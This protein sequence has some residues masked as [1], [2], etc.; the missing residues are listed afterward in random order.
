MRISITFLLVIVAVIAAVNGRKPKAFSCYRS[1]T[2][3]RGGVGSHVPYEG[4]EVTTAGMNSGTGVFTSQESGTWYFSFTGGVYLKDAKNYG[5]GIYKNNNVELSG[6]FLRDGGQEYR[7]SSYVSIATSAMAEVNRGDTIS[8]RV[9]DKDG[10]SHLPGG[11]PK[12]TFIG[13]K[14]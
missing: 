12:A 10:G 4:C 3:F 5:L 1:S 2:S 13:I 14:L 7:K 9:T 11:S 8:V 6:S